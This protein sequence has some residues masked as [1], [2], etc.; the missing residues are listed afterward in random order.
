MNL[1]IF[2]GIPY[3]RTRRCASPSY[4]RS[5]AS[6]HRKC[7]EIRLRLDGGGLK[8][9]LRPGVDSDDSGEDSR[10]AGRRCVRN[11]FG[12]SSRGAFLIPR[13]VAVRSARRGPRFP[14][15]SP[16]S[17]PTRRLPRPGR[18]RCGRRPCVPLSANRF[19][20]P[21]TRRSCRPTGEF[22]QNNT[23]KTRNCP[24]C[25]HQVHTLCA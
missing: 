15:S 10:K 1:S 2:S 5:P 8:K 20:T 16:R 7:G 23:I 17:P 24:K 25:S 19:G 4:T 22:I 13:F 14:S 11:P 12:L 3:S 21:C 18:R 9:S 6:R